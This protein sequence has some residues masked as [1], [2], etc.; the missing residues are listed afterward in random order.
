MRPEIKGKSIAV[1]DTEANGL[2]KTV[3]EM[4][5]ASVF[6][7][8]G[9]QGAYYGNSGNWV[10]AFLRALDSYD[11]LVGHNLIGYD[12][13][14]LK[15]LYG[16]EPAE[17]VIILDTM[18]L[19]RMYHPDIEGGHSLGAWGERLGNKKQDYRPI[20]DPEQPH[21]NPNAGP[22]D[23]P[24]WEQAIYSETMASYC[25][26][27]VD[28]NVDVFW[29]LMELLKNYSWKSI[30][31]EMETAKLIQRQM[32]HGFV[33]D[34]EQAEVLHAKLVERKIELE[35][36]VQR[37]FLPLPKLVREIQ[38]KVK[39]DDTISSVGLKKLVDWETVIPVPEHTRTVEMVPYSVECEFSGDVIWKERK[40][41]KVEYHSGSFSLIEWPEFSLGSRQQIAER[42]TL[43]GY[44]LTKKTEKGNAI[45]DDVVLQEAA[46][47]GIPEAKPLAEY[48]LITKRE[49]MVRDWINRAE[50]HE[51]QGVW[52]IHGYVNS[53]GAATNRMAHSSPNVA[54]V[55]A[56]YSPYGK[57]CRSLFKV[58]PG[59]T[60]VGC[61]A[62]GLELRCL[63][64]YMGDLA[65]CKTVVEGKKEEGTDIHTVNMRAAGLTSRDLAKT[66]I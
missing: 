45:I 33:F 63:A 62:S 39:A 49:G 57:E 52:R 22:K 3:K 47:A 54:Q 12:L 48:F 10:E 15:M 40:V 41:T 38:P 28:V 42:L 64:H 44:K 20:D 36:E 30:I 26:Q 18:W 25:H 24:G 66:F 31:C 4:I 8:N 1:F 29:K 65:Y 60:L 17:H 32:D 14:M 50:W 19:S 51:D 9:K 21:Y 7:A 37:T 56:A 46:E 2:L 13:P 16:W 55:P 61:D 43:A 53:L 27:D 35:D 59:Y 23:D 5:C 34:K 6:S 58:R 11:I